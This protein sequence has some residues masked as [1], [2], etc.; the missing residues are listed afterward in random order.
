ML[1]IYHNPRCKKSRE[2]Y[3]YLSEKGISFKV[4]EYLKEP[5]TLEEL[6]RILKQLNIKPS[7]LVRKNE[8]EWKALPRRN[9]LTEDQILKVMVAFPKTIERPIVTSHEKGILARPIENLFSFLENN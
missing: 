5:L 8:A 1:T 9:E 3:Q 4:V 6:K 7:Q 2:A